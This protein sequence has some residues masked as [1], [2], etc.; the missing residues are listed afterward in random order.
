MSW[1]LRFH[2]PRLSELRALSVCDMLTATMSNLPTPRFRRYV[3]DLPYGKAAALASRLGIHTVYLSQLASRHNGRKPSPEL[4]VD[5]ERATD[6]AVTRRDL[7]PSDW[8]RIWPEL[9]S[10]EFPAPMA[11]TPTTQ[12]PSHA[13]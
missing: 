8:W 6:G 10:D 11:P 5:I 13:G 4:C 3:D 7:R 12:E 9:V 1:A 2:G